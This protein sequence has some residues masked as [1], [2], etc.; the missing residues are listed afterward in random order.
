MLAPLFS[1]ALSRR[2]FIAA[3]TTGLAGL[4]FGSSAAGN[5]QLA[6]R[7]RP[8]KSTILFF[9]CGGASHID[10]WDMKPD[11]PSEY[12]GEFKPIATSAPGVRIC[13]HLPLTAQQGH[14]LALV[15]GVTD[16][17][18]ATGDHHAGYYYNLT[19]HVPDETFKREGNDRRPYPTDWP[20]IGCVVGAKRPPHPKMPSV[21]TLPFK[22]SRAPYTRPGQFA[23]R[24]GM[25][26]DPFFVA[27]NR[28]QPLQFT[29]PTLTLDAGV[30]PARMG[31]RRV[32][33]DA[34]N[35]AR[36]ELDHEAIV[37]NYVRQQEKAFS[38]LASSA[39]AG[40]FDITTEKPTT[41]DRY[42]RTINGMGLLM[43]R[44]LVE[45]GVPFITVFWAES[46]ENV[47]KKCLSGGGWDTHGNN[48]NCLRED[49]LPEFDRGY[50][51]LIEDL[52]QRG[53]LESTLVIV[54]SEMGR[55]PMIGDP[56]SA[57]K[58]AA[59]RDHW[60]A[61]MSV[62]MA[63]G[64][65][66]GGQ[67]VG[68]TDPRA[69]YPAEMPIGPEDVAKS[70]YHAMGIENLEATDFQGRPYNLLEEG[71]PLGALFS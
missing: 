6:P 41:L 54:T 36:R 33:L 7:K 56:R 26:F 55:K 47:A 39:T 57:G 11:A 21:V 45:A 28:E 23:G 70:V 18:R 65:V 66:R 17:G 44:R 12:R 24:L 31:D 42:G 32:L 59:G 50:S 62:V 67:I 5:S 37:N 64:G 58:V 51:A 1:P 53:L 20:S 63:G 29:A 16:Y 3:S 22:P 49:L 68:A 4:S 46:D 69:E 13:E 9:L 40:A 15:H 34:V 2:A 25:E 10:M 48:F 38:L 14:H 60:T 8:A 30:S 27:G 52:H 35:A 61:C 71:R 43:A 19:G